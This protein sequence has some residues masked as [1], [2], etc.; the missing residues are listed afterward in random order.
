MT[1]NDDEKPWDVKELRL[2]L[3]GD[4]DSWV[5]IDIFNDDSFN[6]KVY[7]GGEEEWWRENINLDAARRLRDFLIYALAEESK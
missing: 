4:G 5:K 1:D 2:C 3:D 7:S 6:I